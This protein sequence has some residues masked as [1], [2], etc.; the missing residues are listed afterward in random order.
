MKPRPTDPRRLDIAFAAREGV[1]LHGEW[2]LAGF[3]RLA[4]PHDLAGPAVT[5][6]AAAAQ[7][8]RSGAAL[9]ASLHLVAQ[10]TVTRECQRC[11]KP[12]ALALAVDRRF[13]FAADEASA[14]ALD[15][16]TD[17]AD[18]LVLTPRLDLHDLVE[19]ELLLALPIVPRHERC[20]EPLAPSAEPA[21]PAEA[22]AP[23]HPFAA[24]AA[25]KRPH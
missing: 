11:L 4:E 23:A 9:Q 21:A 1:E 15:A 6:S 12:M 8:S 25:L 24:L 7:R 22:D 2:P 5:W 3:E 14:A 16:E 19:D 13:L 18:V 20:P 17:E 10:A